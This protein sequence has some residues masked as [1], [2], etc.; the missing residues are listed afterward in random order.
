[1]KIVT[2]LHHMQNGEVNVG[3]YEFYFNS[4]YSYVT[5]FFSVL[6]SN[7]ADVD[8]KAISFLYVCP[9]HFV[10]FNSVIHRFS[11]TCFSQTDV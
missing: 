10:L 9:H 8:T 2:F 3:L 1:M 7:A 11:T 5:S 6:L 4:N